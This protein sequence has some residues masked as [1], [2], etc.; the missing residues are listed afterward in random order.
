MKDQILNQTYN[1]EALMSETTELP[2][3]LAGMLALSNRIEEQIA[4][5]GGELTDEIVAMLLNQDVAL[6]KKVDGTVFVIKRMEM[7]E[8]MF[9]AESDRYLKVARGLA[10][11]ASRLREYVKSE[12]DR[13]RTAG[14]ER[15]SKSLYT[16]ELKARSGSRFGQAA[17]PIH[18]PDHIEIG[19]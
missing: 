6:P 12:H 2:Q 3:T 18:N 1:Q 8:E 9:K 7:G 5:G 15:R 10:N 13:S 14:T 17:R 11:A 16:S 4:Q 19:K